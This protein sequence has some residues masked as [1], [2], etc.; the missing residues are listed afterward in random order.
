MVKDGDRRP[1]RNSQEAIVQP[2]DRVL[3]YSTI[4]LNLFADVETSF[5]WEKL[6]IND[7]VLP[8]SFRNQTSWNLNVDDADSYLPHHQPIRRTSMN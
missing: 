6:A 7:K 1:G 2:W 8:Q 4:S 3:I 5:T